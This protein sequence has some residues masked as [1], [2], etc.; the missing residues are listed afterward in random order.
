MVE[1]ST[2]PRLALAGRGVLA[3]PEMTMNTTRHST[4]R[5]AFSMIEVIM[6]ILV[7]GI[8]ATI[9][10]PRFADAGTGR[11]LNAAI[12]IVE[13]DI[14]SVKLRAR[15]TGKSHLIVFYPADEMYVA[16]EGL[17][18]DRNQIVL[19]RSLDSSTLDVELSRTNIGDNEDIVVSELGELEKDFSIG[20][21]N[22]GIEEI[23]SFTGVGFTRPTVTETDSVVE[24]KTGILD[25]SLGEG[26]LG[27][28]LGL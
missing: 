27:L 20:V 24:I 6:V 25:V 4:T 13:D 17:E 7:M 5:A 23:I 8:I 11:K 14:D 19:A 18:I 2:P 16:F 10:A 12:S 26:G 22:Q 3:F 9:A 21:M 28:K 15:A 1:S